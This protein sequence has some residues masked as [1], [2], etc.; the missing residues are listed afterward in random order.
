MRT[1]A[2]GIIERMA[3]LGV[4]YGVLFGIVSGALSFL[5]IGLFRSGPFEDLE[6]GIGGACFFI[7]VGLTMGGAIGMVWGLAVGLASGVTLALITM[8]TLDALIRAGRYYH[9]T[10]VLLAV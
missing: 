4:A 7:L 1:I 3:V 8:L 6:F 5:A 2:L 9:T 10:L